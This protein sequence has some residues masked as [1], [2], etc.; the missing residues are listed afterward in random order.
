ME[1]IGPKTTLHSSIAGQ[2][3]LPRPKGIIDSCRPSMAKE[4]PS[5]TDGHRRVKMNDTEQREQ[6]PRLRRQVAANLC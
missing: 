5:S 6:K 1:G 2:P 4:D 3:V